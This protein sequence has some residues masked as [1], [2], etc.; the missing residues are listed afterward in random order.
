MASAALEQLRE[1]ALEL[2]ELDRAALAHDLLVSLDGPPDS[3]ANDAWSTEI[4]RRIAEVDAGSV[5]L[6]DAEEVSRRVAER[7]RGNR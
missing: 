3:D 7:V 5:Q 2:S 1:K 6:V 4:E